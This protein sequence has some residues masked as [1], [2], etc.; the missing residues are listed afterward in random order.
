MATYKVV[1]LDNEHIELQTKAEADYYQRAQGKYVSENVFTAASD[2]RALD[3]L[4]LME[5]LMFR[6]QSQLASGMDYNKNPLNYAEQ[7]ALRKNIKEGAIT[8]SNAH[9]ELGLTKTQRE[10]DQVESVQAYVNN[11][12]SRAKEFGVHREEQVDLAINLINEL[13]AHVGAYS[14]SNDYE[15]KRIGFETAEDIVKWILE[16]LEPRWK[17]ID[18]AWRDSSQKYWRSEI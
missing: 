8:I 16:E 11:L 13:L 1:T 6:W 7:E 18:D 4:V 15:K 2:E 10:K 3:R 17:A 9:Q 5:T 12:L 14:R